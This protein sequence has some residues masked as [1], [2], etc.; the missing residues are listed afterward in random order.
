MLKDFLLTYSV[1]NK[2]PK[3]ESDREKADKI[4]R[5]IAELTCWN[6]LK[7]VE[8]T[9]SGDMD[10]TGASDADKKSSAKRNIRSEFI[11]IMKLHGARSLDVTI[12]CAIMIE[13]VSGV[14]EFEIENS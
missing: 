5:D 6:K 4:R 8:T 1:K 9:F 3:I 7:N 12:Y 14:Y 2:F 13:G 10:I 11:P